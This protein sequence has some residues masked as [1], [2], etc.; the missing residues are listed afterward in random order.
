MGA[1][2]TSA[3]ATSPVGVMERKRS[4][5]SAGAR[6]V[7]QSGELGTRH[8]SLSLFQAVGKHGRATAGPM[9][10]PPSSSGV[11]V[12]LLLWPAEIPYNA[13]PMRASA[14]IE[15]VRELGCPTMRSALSKTAQVLAGVAD[16]EGD[17]QSNVPSD[18]ST[19]AMIF[20]ELSQSANLR[21]R[22]VPTRAAKIPPFSLATESIGTRIHTT[23]QPSASGTSAPTPPPSFDTEP[24][25]MG[26]LEHDVAP[27]LALTPAMPPAL[28]PAC[29]PL[30]H[31]N[32]R[33]ANA[34]PKGP[35]Q[36][37]MLWTMRLERGGGKDRKSTSLN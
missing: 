7:P 5:Q 34:T 31:P 3:L 19:P 17:Q 28:L 20:P 4:S 35:A 6:C 25:L 37:F 24:T 14:W 27:P 12:G 16:H 10:V 1:I 22:S 11:S 2:A 26:S 15:P 29:E 33:T 23:V 36:P 21:T 8:A 32:P 9:G 30:S 18:V 13:R